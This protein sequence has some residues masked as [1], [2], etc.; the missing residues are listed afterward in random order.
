MT[1]AK[2]KAAAATKVSKKVSALFKKQLNFQG[3][4]LDLKDTKKNRG[5]PEFVG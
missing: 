2:T 1:I 4:K 5:Y 3:W